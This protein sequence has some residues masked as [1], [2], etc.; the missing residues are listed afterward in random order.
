MFSTFS[1]FSANNI[2]R[3]N[4]AEGGKDDSGSDFD[5]LLAKTSKSLVKLQGLNDVQ[6]T[7]G[8]QDKKKDSLL[9]KVLGGDT[10]QM[11]FGAMVFA[12]LVIAT[13]GVAAST[14][15]P[16]AV[17]A[18]GVFAAGVGGALVAK[19]VK[20]FR[21]ASKSQGSLG[22]QV[23]STLEQLGNQLQ[24]NLKKDLGVADKEEKGPDLSSLLSSISS[25]LPGGSKSSPEIDKAQSD[26]LKKELTKEISN[27]LKID[28][29][30]EKEK[31]LNQEITDL[32]GRFYGN[33]KK[34]MGDNKFC[35]STSSH[36]PEETG[37]VLKKLLDKDGINKGDNAISPE[38]KALK[39]IMED[40]DSKGLKE[41]KLVLKTLNNIFDK[42]DDQVEKDEE[43]AQATN[44]KNVLANII[45]KDSSILVDSPKE[46]EVKELIKAQKEKFDKDKVSKKQKDTERQ[47]QKTGLGI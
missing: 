23:S 37:K 16:L 8:Q 18:M 28:T 47:K 22:S 12:F 9:S 34:V 42:C 27:S 45:K 33:L 30:K 7:F 1:K 40:Y 14:A 31:N 38:A 36:I 46:N 25:F 15:G 5:A 29:I 43:K 39:D 35:D 32:Q 26:A 21:N 10:N 3:I 6:K 17:A 13:M 20:K 24:N 41:K 19:A 4:R 44:K 2:D 11:I